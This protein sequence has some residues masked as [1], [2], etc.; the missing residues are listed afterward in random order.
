MADSRRSKMLV[1]DPEQNN[2]NRTSLTH[3]SPFRIPGN[4]TWFQNELVGDDE[5]K[6]YRITNEIWM[7]IAGRLGFGKNIVK[8]LQSMY[9]K[10]SKRSVE[11]VATS[12][13]DLANLN[14]AEWNKENEFAF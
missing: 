14:H 11:M 7:G 4:D 12:C 13:F 1:V 6:L 3:S 9:E 5:E 10:S 8:S 2:V